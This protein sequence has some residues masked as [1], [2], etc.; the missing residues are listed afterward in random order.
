MLDWWGRC[1]R[2]AVGV[3][4]GKGALGSVV[5][6]VAAVAAATWCGC[7]VVGGSI[8]VATEGDMSARYKDLYGEPQRTYEVV[9]AKGQV[10]IDGKPDEPAWQQAGV[11][12]DMVVA[13][14]LGKPTQRTEVRV[15]WD[16]EFLYVSFVCQD[17]F[18]YNTYTQQDDP[19]FANQDCVE[20]FL[21]PDMDPRL[22]YELNVSPANVT[23]TGISYRPLFPEK[24]HHVFTAFN[25]RRFATAARVDGQLNAEEQNSKVWSVEYAIPF[26]CLGTAPHRPP[27]VGDR[28]RANFYRIDLV[29]K[30][31]PK[32]QV[33]FISWSP[34]G[35]INFH[36]P[37]EFG[38]I[39]FVE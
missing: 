1:R 9:R 22:Y 13:D 37:H 36:M 21:N 6:C 3:L 5:L 31:E 38:E 39:V 2:Q 8:S 33:E 23:W 4:G 28:W 29:E 18:I 17:R 12:K 11:I 30:R 35:I 24:P 25:P 20:V 14:T 15:L 32:D 27:Q 10:T 34:P 16:D 19:I 7:V 26:D